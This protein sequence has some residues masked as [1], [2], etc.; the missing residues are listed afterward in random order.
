MEELEST[1]VKCI[2]LLNGVT[3]KG[4]CASQVSRDYVGVLAVIM[5]AG[6]GCGCLP[7]PCCLFR[8]YDDFCDVEGLLVWKRT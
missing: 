7:A 6:S 3:S 2:S 8:C 4:A 1:P 5:V